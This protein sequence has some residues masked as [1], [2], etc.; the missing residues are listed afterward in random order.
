[1][2][3][4]PYDDV[5]SEDCFENSE[6][7]EV[8]NVLSPPSPTCLRN[9]TVVS[10]ETLLED[11]SWSN[12]SESF[13]R[14]EVL[15]DETFESSSNG[16]STRGLLS[17]VLSK[18]YN[19]FRNI[20]S[21]SSTSTAAANSPD[22]Q[23]VCTKSSIV[24]DLYSAESRNVLDDQVKSPSG[25]ERANS[26]DSE[27]D[28]SS[29]SDSETD[30]DCRPPRVSKDVLLC[31]QD[32]CK[33]LAG[34]KQ[35]M[36]V[37]TG[38][39]GRRVTRRSLQSLLPSPRSSARRTLRSSQ[40]F[41]YDEIT[42]RRRQISKKEKIPKEKFDSER[43]KTP[44]KQSSRRS[45]KNRYGSFTSKNRGSTGVTPYTESDCDS[46]HDCG[47]QSVNNGKTG[48]T[49]V[50]DGNAG[51]ISMH[52]TQLP[53]SRLHEIGGSSSSDVSRNQATMLDNIALRLGE[54]LATNLAQGILFDALTT[55]IQLHCP[56]LL[57][58]QSDAINNNNN[59]STPTNNPALGMDGTSST[60]N[61][62]GYGS[63]GA[64]ASKPALS[65][66]VRQSVRVTSEGVCYSDGRKRGAKSP[67]IMDCIKKG[68]A[69]NRDASSC[70]PT[71][72]TV[73]WTRPAWITDSVDG[74][75]SPGSDS[76]R[77]NSP[78]FS[79]Y[80]RE[81][82][83]F[84]TVAPPSKLVTEHQRNNASPPK[85][86]KT[87]SSDKSS[88]TILQPRSVLTSSNDGSSTD[89]SSSDREISIKELKGIS[90]TVAPLP[91]S[92]SPRASSDNRRYIDS[93]SSSSSSD[94][95]RLA[96]AGLQRRDPGVKNMTKPTS[97]SEYD[98]TP[99][100]R[101]VNSRKRL[102]FRASRFHKTTEPRLRTRHSYKE[103][104]FPIRPTFKSGRRRSSAQSSSSRLL[105][106][107]VL[108]RLARDE[109][110]ELRVAG[111][112]PEDII[113]SCE[114]SSS[115]ESEEGSEASLRRQEQPAR[116]GAPDNENLGKD[117]T[118]KGESEATEYLQLTA[119]ESAKVASSGNLRHTKRTGVAELKA[120]AADEWKEMQKTGFHPKNILSNILKKDNLRKRTSQF[121]AASTPQAKPSYPFRVRGN[122]NSGTSDRPTQVCLAPFVGRDVVSTSVSPSDSWAV[123]QVARKGMDRPRGWKQLMVLTLDE[124]KELR[125]TGFHPCDVVNNYMTNFRRVT[126]PDV[127]REREE[128]DEKC[129]TDCETDDEDSDDA[130]HSLKRRKKK[131][132][133]SA[134]SR[135]TVGSG[136]SVMRNAQH[137]VAEAAFSDSPSQVVRSKGFGRRELKNLMVDELKEFRRTGFHPVDIVNT[138]KTQDS[139]PSSSEDRDDEHEG[140]A[141]F[142]HKESLRSSKS[143]AKEDEDEKGYETDTDDVNTPS[144]RKEKK[145]LS[146]E[147][148]NLFADECKE[149]M[150]RRNV[151]RKRGSPRHGGLRRKLVTGVL[152]VTHSSPKRSAGL[153]GIVLSTA[154]S[155]N[156]RYQ[157]EATSF[158]TQRT[159]RS[160][161]KAG[162]VPEAM[163]TVRNYQRDMLQVEGAMCVVNYR[164]PDI[165]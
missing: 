60:L 156:S 45:L 158:R 11:C 28:S 78:N 44:S 139:E 27:D 72:D 33:E 36:S 143:N 91:L 87:A 69:K 109:W 37:D 102:R 61:T 147:L 25:Q 4:G 70:E 136:G 56:Q 107:R 54:S 74:G 38:S 77:C 73:A 81:F 88:E 12:C 101:R 51:T 130:S 145:S 115:S 125:K 152:P 124:C 134:R 100:I 127:E 129:Y 80:S 23:N 52:V 35:L 18:G 16:G 82:S 58:S 71:P 142:A 86:G 3:G 104:N 84:R 43:I 94:D 161:D 153:S 128:K 112:H 137:G 68:R 157:G 79:F 131:N 110:K 29:D 49:L 39:T 155:S 154:G 96:P 117:A 141:V 20:V 116:Q 97:D 63:S 113:E 17:S 5:T 64:I 133:L 32:E 19:F 114:G 53:A 83:N 144:S 121:L 10:A 6:M 66:P 103:N 8:E 160:Q 47:N 123:G 98:G 106:R 46:E 40:F 92:N 163:L 99:L 2:S 55:S 75:D 50:G 111:C 48:K 62:S 9:L 14:Q 126:E 30:A 93:S 122:V 150:S 26:S 159:V 108:A 138:F 67:S 22:Q 76:T 41:R 15:Q 85:I 1:M 140:K 162:V 89:T 7:F 118:D 164:L 119:M 31:L 135:N 146:T 13:S 149:L 95:A 57:F 59:N 21:S 105:K 24:A 65:S 120:L 90:S 34:L 42:D 148:R 151:V 132:S 165:S